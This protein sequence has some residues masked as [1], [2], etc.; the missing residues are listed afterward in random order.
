MTQTRKRL[1]GAV[2]DEW[3]LHV[4]PVRDGRLRHRWG[5]RDGKR[6]RVVPVRDE[7][8]RGRTAVR[9]GRPR[10]GGSLLVGKS[11]RR[12]SNP[13]DY[14]CAKGYPDRILSTGK[15]RRVREDQDSRVLHEGADQ[16]YVRHTYGGVGEVDP[17]RRKGRQSLLSRRRRPRRSRRRVDSKDSSQGEGEGDPKT[18]TLDRGE[19]RDYR[20]PHGTTVSKYKARDGEVLSSG[21][22]FCRVG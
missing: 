16:P 21:F 1:G 20:N 4:G 19:N 6:R 18:R 10:Q 13:V 5:V 9:D 14:S 7:Q 22:L 2:R 15:S 8:C 12:E 17:P 11:R 3:R